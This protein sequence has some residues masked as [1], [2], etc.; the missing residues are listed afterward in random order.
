[1]KE[2]PI[3]FSG[4]MV[5]AI[6]SGAK[7]QTRRPFDPAKIKVRLPREVHSD[8][9][10][11][12][13]LQPMPIIAE[14][15]IHKA[16]LCGGGAV[17]LTDTSS[18]LGVKPGE[19]HF[20]CPWADGD[21]HLGDYGKD[22]KRWTI[23]PRDSAL[24]VRETH[25]SA[26]RYYQGHEND[27]PSVIAYRADQSA[28][29]FE[30]RRP[31]AVPAR[32]TLS[33]NWDLMKWRPSI[34]MPRWASRIAVPVVAVRIE[35]VQD[36]TAEDAQAEGVTVPQC[37]CEVCSRGTAICPADATSYIEGFRDLWC[38]TYGRESWEANQW[39]WV[40]QWS[41]AQVTP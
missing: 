29:Q 1:V 4:D 35:R 2:T 7:T 23:T 40:I 37:G 15:G 20:V 24:W 34:H 26:D 36:I 17:A 32:D 19:F 5:R 21:T 41:K 14:P 10:G 8:S 13:I 11:L 18:S 30:A 27:V 31:V 28:I 9:F 38:A 33:W 25:G 39:V 3:L 22:G 6:L 16:R 12:G